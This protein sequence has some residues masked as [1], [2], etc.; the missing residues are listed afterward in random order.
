MRV[1]VAVLHFML[2]KDLFQQTAPWRIPLKYMYIAPP[3]AADPL[4]VAER[5]DRL[6]T[7]QT[8]HLLCYVDC[9]PLAIVA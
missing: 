1:A 8:E 7:T 3:A 2:I 4:A 6:T 9:H 5:T